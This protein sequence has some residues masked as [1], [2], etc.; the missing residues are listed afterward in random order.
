MNIVIVYISVQSTE[1]WLAALQ[2]YAL[3]CVFCLQLT[4]PYN[5]EICALSQVFQNGSKGFMDEDRMGGLANLCRRNIPISE[6]HIKPLPY[7]FQRGDN[8]LDETG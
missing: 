4:E 3:M 8:T 1:S 5:G 6:Q 2:D 7:A